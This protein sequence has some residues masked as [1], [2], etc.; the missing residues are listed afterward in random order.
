MELVVWLR[1]PLA[2]VQ[3]KSS[4]DPILDG[5]LFNAISK[6]DSSWTI[7]PCRTSI[8]PQMG[9]DPLTRAE[10]DIMTIELEKTS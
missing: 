7:R 6:D 4:P 5:E 3:M 8:F 2:Q 1:E 9:W 10:D